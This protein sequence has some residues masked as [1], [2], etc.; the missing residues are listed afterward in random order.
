MGGP[1]ALIDASTSVSGL[2]EVMD[3]VSIKDTGN[4][5]NYDGSMIPW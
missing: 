1:N 4:F 5:F 3:Q 2:I